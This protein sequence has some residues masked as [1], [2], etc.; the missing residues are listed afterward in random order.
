MY[1]Y[2]YVYIYTYIHIYTYTTMTVL[3]ADGIKMVS[4]L[5]TAQES[6][7]GHGASAPYLFID[8]YIDRDIDIDI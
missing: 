1:V 7:R 2:I 8:M 6:L 5:F 4:A 3:K